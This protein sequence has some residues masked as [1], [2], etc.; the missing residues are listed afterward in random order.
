MTPRRLLV[1]VILLIAAS[2]CSKDE[3]PTAPTTACT[4]TAGAISASTFG[5][6][7]GTGSVP[8]IAGS[9]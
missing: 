6:A 5:A 7:G 4:V 3:T 2:A 1:A 9:G 8:I